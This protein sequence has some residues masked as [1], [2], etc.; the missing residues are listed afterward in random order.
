MIEF[1]DVE[2]YLDH[3][4][5]DYVSGRAKNVGSGWIALQ[6]PFCDDPSNHLGIRLEDKKVS[7]WRCGGHLLLELLEKLE[8]G[9]SRREAWKIVHYFKDPL[10]VKS[11][12][13]EQSTARKFSIPKNFLTLGEHPNRSQII[14]Y[15]NS[16][17][18]HQ[19]WLRSQ[20]RR[21]DFAI[22][23]PNPFHLGDYKFRFM[24]PIYQGNRLVNFVGRDISSK[25]PIPYKPFPNQEALLPIKQTLYGIDNIKDGDSI[26]IVEGILDCWKLGKGSVATH[27]IGWSKSQLLLLHQKRPKKIFILF[28]SEPE[29]QKA[30]ERFAAH[31]WFAET[32]VNS[33][34]SHPDPGSLTLDQ[35]RELMK[36]LQNSGR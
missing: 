14:D 5:I 25:S 21:R 10:S 6:C 8:G 4:R 3:R 7:C 27:G 24:I 18:F 17:G 9:I 29:A 22:Y 31:I 11:P 1:F 15:L 28:D 13:P 19:A 32:E 12:F 35:G 2:A 26:V 36:L 30:A 34:N 20:E 23:G 16:R 33:L